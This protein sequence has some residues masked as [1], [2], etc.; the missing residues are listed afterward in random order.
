MEDGRLARPDQS[1]ASLDRADE[2]VRSYV[3]F[4]EVEK[5]SATGF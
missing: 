5:H 4:A 3:V 2:G 1:Q